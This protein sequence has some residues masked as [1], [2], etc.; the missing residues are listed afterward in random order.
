MPTS[1]LQPDVWAQ[2][3][4]SE[5]AVPETIS[6]QCGHKSTLSATYQL[7]DN[8]QITWAQFW[9]WKMAIELSF[10][11]ETHMKA[12]STM[13]LGTWRALNKQQLL[14]SCN[15]QQ[16]NSPTQIHKLSTH[17]N[18]FSFKNIKPLCHGPQLPSNSSTF[19]PCIPSVHGLP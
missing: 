5:Y 9:V 4:A 3:P 17:K 13:M 14:Y 15:C 1:R 16:I 7:W 6:Q 19:A 12:D 18:N 11:Q 2:K 10:K 8:G